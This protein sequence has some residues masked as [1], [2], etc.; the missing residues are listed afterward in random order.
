[1]TRLCFIIL[2]TVS[3]FNSNTFAQDTSVEGKYGL[4][5]SAGYFLPI[6][7]LYE[8]F[9]GGPKIALKGSYLTD[10][11]NYEAEFYYSNFSSGK[12]EDL[13][14]KWPYD[15]EYYAS[16]DA[17]S[18]MEFLGVLVNFK[19]PT[20]LDWS[21]L[22]LYYSVGAGFT[23]YEYQIKDM[24]YPGQLTTAINMDFTYSPDVE[25]HTALHVNVGAGLQYF[26]TPAIY[27]GLNCRYNVIASSLR[28]MEA[29][30][31]EKVSPL[32]LLDINFEFL[33]YF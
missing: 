14:F 30:L 10:D 4:G 18:Q 11:I 8:R 2:L 5:I 3:I 21:G 16:P 28:P 24:V 26:V 17:S 29:W 22:S 33:Y 12:I 19:F 32:Q 15:S 7:K 1:M 9:N 20:G 23:Y 27:L 31:L 25:K 13:S 6:G